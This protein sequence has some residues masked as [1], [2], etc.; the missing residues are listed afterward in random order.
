MHILAVPGGLRAG[1]I[2]PRFRVDAN[3]L[4]ARL[5]LA[6]SNCGSADRLRPSSRNV[7]RD[8]FV[9][10]IRPTRAAPIWTMAC[11]GSE[12]ARRAGFPALVT[13]RISADRTKR[14]RMAALFP[15]FVGPI[16]RRV[17]GFEGSRHRRPID[18]VLTPPV[19][20]T[21]CAPRA[22]A[23]CPSHYMA[24]HRS[25]SHAREHGMNGVDSG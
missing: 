21:F 24:M 16:K 3:T 7:R 23:A 18:R 20:G 8:L 22:G 19:C 9:I 10:R 11:L 12:A 5:R 6:A 2:A 25:G 1:R 17:T 13:P 4:I 15:A 14:R